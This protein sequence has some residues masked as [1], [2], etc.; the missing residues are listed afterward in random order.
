[1]NSRFMRNGFIYL[2]I[3]VAVIAI[4]FTLFSDVPGG[5]KDLGISE[6]VAM[7]KRGDIDT[8]EVRGD[9]LTIITTL[10]E[11]F[12]SR[13]EQNVSIVEILVDAGIDPYA[14][15]KPRIVVEGSSGL[16]S[17]FGILINFLPLI[18]FGAVL[19]F[20]MRQAQGSTNQTFSFGRS[21]A[22]MQVGNQPNVTF[23]DVAGADEA[24]E[25]LEEVVDFLILG[26]FRGPNPT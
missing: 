10:Q 26:T 18:F 25:E 13:I 7:A 22:R 4:F 5:S 3:V 6:V 8:I 23:E 9:R 11:T 15:G 16:G 19:L 24:K 17:L 21:R 20:M 14:G 12:T 2:L 1:M